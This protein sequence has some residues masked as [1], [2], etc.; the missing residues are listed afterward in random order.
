MKYTQKQ[1]VPIV[2][3]V[4]LVCLMVVLRT[5]V[6]ERAGKTGA[7]VPQI[8]SVGNEGSQVSSDSK[9]KSQNTNGSNKV[10][11]DDATPESTRIP[12]AAQKRYYTLAAPNDPRYG[13]AWYLQTVNAP[14]AWDT[15]TGSSAV[16]VAVIDTGFALAHQE[17]TDRWS[18]NLGDLVDGLDNDGNGYTDDYLGWDF[19]TDDSSP[20]AG[21]LDPNGSG[22][23]HG[24]E[25]SGLVGATGNNSIGTSAISWNTSIMP[26]QVI[27]DSGSGYSDDVAEAIYYAVDRGVDVINMSLGTSGDDPIVRAAVD[28]AFDSNVVVVA[29]AG[30]CG[31]A[32]STGACTGQPTGYITFPAS[33]N[34]VIAVGAT[35]STSA[36]A[37]FSS[38]GERLDVMAPGSGSIVSPTWVNGN[39]TS[40]YAE[41]IYGTSYASPIVASSVALI[42]SIRPSSSV[43]DVRALVMAG[44]AKISSMSGSFYTQGYG[45]GMLDVGKMVTIA[46]DLNTS[47]EQVPELFQAGGVQSEHSYG[48]ADTIGSGCT[49]SALTW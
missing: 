49:D 40:S 23:S 46:S 17:L 42:K 4:V 11:N 43:D 5:P 37:N 14:S 1:I 38:Y 47:G 3:M 25:V 29:A 32:G 7:T 2:A 12:G 22:T 36:R 16:T 10:A 20:Q 13:A 35:T 39:G 28:Y 19:V 44:A 6:T 33:Y 15:T 41:N 18:L 31:N 26:L 9:P 27:D 34:R 21:E 48:T 24:T 30:N 45:H 8:G